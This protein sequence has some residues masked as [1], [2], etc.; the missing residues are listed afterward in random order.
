MRNIL[1]IDILKKYPLA[2]L[3]SLLLM[4]SF[5][6]TP[7]AMA[8]YVTSASFD[9]VAQVAKFDVE[10]IPPVGWNI[11]AS[12]T[13][14]IHFTVP[15]NID[16]VNV[17]FTIN[18]NSEVTIRVRAEA[19]LLPPNP[20]LVQDLITPPIIMEPGSSVDVPIEIFEATSPTSDPY[21]SPFY[22]VVIAE[23]VD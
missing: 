1:K 18:N 10:V 9:N 14:E 5:L 20:P 17:P 23:Q 3:A 6:T 13:N 21:L 7:L 15:T 16:S 4:L 8:R 22:L 11:G 2:K 19:R 12:A